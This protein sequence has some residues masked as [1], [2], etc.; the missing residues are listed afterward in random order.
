MTQLILSTALAFVLAAGGTQAV[1]TQN[2]PSERRPRDAQLKPPAEDDQPLTAQQTAVVR[3]VL[4]KYKKSSLTAADAK[5]INESFRAAGLK[6]GSGLQKAIQ[7]A[8]FDT[9]KLSALAPPPNQ[10]PADRSQ[11]QEERKAPSSKQT[12]Q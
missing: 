4:S 12:Q 6:R 3:K 7:D 5:A 11:G 9:R 2:P 8:G 10:G 1:Q